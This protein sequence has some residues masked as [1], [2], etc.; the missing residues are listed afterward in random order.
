MPDQEMQCIKT[1]TVDPTFG[2]HGTQVLDK[3]AKD[4]SVHAGDVSWAS[5]FND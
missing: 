2:H 1:E 3:S 5:G 4:I